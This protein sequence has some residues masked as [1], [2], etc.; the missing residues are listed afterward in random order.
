[1]TPADLHAALAP[2]TAQL[3]GR[4]LNDDL[5]AWLNI[6]YGP[7]STSYAKLKAV[8]CFFRHIS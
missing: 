6:E 5:E 4:P 7:G 3:V 8:R 2:L 1:M